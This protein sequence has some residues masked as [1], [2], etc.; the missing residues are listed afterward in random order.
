MEK[1][2]LAGHGSHRWSPRLGRV[3]YRAQ[4]AE[5]QIIRSCHSQNHDDSSGATKPAFLPI[6]YREAPLNKKGHSI[7]FGEA[8]ESGHRFENV[9]EN[10]V[11]SSELE[12]AVRGVGALMRGG[13]WVVHRMKAVECLGRESVHYPLRFRSKIRGK[14]IPPFSDKMRK[15]RRQY[16]SR[17]H[18]NRLSPHGPYCDVR[19]SG[20]SACCQACSKRHCALLASSIRPCARRLCA[21]P[22]S[23]Q[24]FSAK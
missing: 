13:Y 3:Y 19:A 18:F 8:G 16:R 7:R 15:D 1:G 22:C 21:R 17:P 9:E 20:T 11:P 14:F 12:K 23:D 6:H 2:V 5:V 10:I 4:C 24:P